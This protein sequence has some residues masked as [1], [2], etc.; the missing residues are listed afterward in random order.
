MGEPMIDER[1]AVWDALSEFF[2]DTELRETDYQRIAAVLVNSGYPMEKLRD[3]LFFEVYPACYSNLLD[4]AGEWA[5]F[6]PEW[7]ARN[8]APRKDK[9]PL[10]PTSGLYF[11]SARC[12]AGC[13]GVIGSASPIL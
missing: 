7:I 11:P 10:L 5:G 13:S 2:L 4:V 8:I 6:P 3:I 9:R 1:F 12:S